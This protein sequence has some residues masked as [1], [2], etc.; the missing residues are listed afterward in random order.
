VDIS[1][2]GKFETKETEARYARYAML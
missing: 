1:S 2:G